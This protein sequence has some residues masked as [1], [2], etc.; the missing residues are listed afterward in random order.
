MAPPPLG[1]DIEGMSIAFDW[2]PRAAELLVSGTPL[3]AMPWLV[4]FFGFKCLFRLTSEG[5]SRQVD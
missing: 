5:N 2:E 4:F 3:F 1:R